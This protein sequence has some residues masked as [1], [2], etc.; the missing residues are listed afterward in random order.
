MIKISVTAI[1]LTAASVTGALASGPIAPPPPVPP[2]PL[3]MSAPWTGF[4]V[5][6]ALGYGASNYDIGAS[7]SNPGIPLN[8]GLNLPDLGG[9]G[10]LYGLQAGYNYQLSNA[11]VI[12][13][14]I[15]AIG[16]GITNDTSLTAVLGPN[17]LAATYD[18]NVDSMYTI[19]GRVGRLTSPDTMVYGLLGF[20]RGN[21][22]GAYAASVNGTPLAAGGYDFSLNGLAVG[23]GMETMLSSNVSLALE[24]RY[25]HMDRYTFYN[26]PLVGGDT[27]DVG[28]DTS[29]HTVRAMINYRF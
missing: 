23:I 13:A 18:L 4:Y 14:Q 25:N 8:L 1:V 16:T 3:P 29:V 7:Y 5:G 20:T 21:F 26:G 10:G 11:W 19:S 6:G 12:G 9:Q 22:S 27:L 17:S 28:F 24:Y 2:A 15:D